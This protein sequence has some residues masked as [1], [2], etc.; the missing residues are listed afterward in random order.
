MFWL[1]PSVIIIKIKSGFI[2]YDC[3][4]R[5]LN[6]TRLSLLEVVKCELPESR[7]NIMRKYVR[8]LQIN[9]YS[10]TKI[11]QCKFEVHRTIY[12][13]GMHA[14]IS[15]VLNGEN[16]CINN[17]SKGACEDVHKTGIKSY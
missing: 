10:E 1:F 13:C 16:E 7:I 5:Y 17:F 9:D 4:S 6:M 12:Y 11:I 3:G 8:L 15:I 14:H 2:G